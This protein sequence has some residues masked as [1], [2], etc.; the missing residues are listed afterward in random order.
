MVSKHYVKDRVE[1]ERLIKTIGI[2]KEVATF[3]VD[4][5]HPNGPELH[6]ITST[7]IIIIRNARTHKLVTKLIARPNQ[8]RRYFDKETEIVKKLILIAEIHQKRGY[9]QI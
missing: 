6:T 8:I 7:G 1:R 9:N 3:K 4:K 5:G 2:G